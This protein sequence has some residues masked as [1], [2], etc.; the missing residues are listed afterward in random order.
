M[1]SLEAGVKYGT[2]V[3]SSP[4]PAIGGGVEED[5]SAGSGNEGRGGQQARLQWQSLAPRRWGRAPR[6]E[7]VEVVALEKASCG[8]IRDGRES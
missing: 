8:K 4:S 7:E 3:T 1:R 5:A 2:V 6:V